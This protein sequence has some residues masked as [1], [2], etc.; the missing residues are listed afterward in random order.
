MKPPLGKESDARKD[1][2]DHR[3]KTPDNKDT[4]E[5]YPE[6]YSNSQTGE[7][8]GSG[9]RSNLSATLGLEETGRGDHVTTVCAQPTVLEQ[10]FAVEDESS[11][12]NWVVQTNNLSGE[13]GE[14][15]RTVG[16]TTALTKTAERMEAASTQVVKR[17]H[18]V[19]M[20]E[21][22]DKD[23]NVSFQRWLAAGSL[24]ISPKPHVVALPTLPE[25]LTITKRPLPNV[26]VA[27]NDVTRTGVTLPMVAMPLVASA[28]AQEVPHRW[29]KPFEVDWML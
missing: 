10:T 15:T 1:R 7:P 24:T 13:S 17:G 8:E 23:N 29:M 28:K 5:V 27:L 19:T 18:Q 3:N 16:C 22:P 11:H 20:I 26:G 6:V 2:T 12:G 9:L 14:D 21:V 25:S 4:L